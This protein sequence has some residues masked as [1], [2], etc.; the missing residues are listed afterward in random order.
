MFY[1]E[2]FQHVLKKFK[3]YLLKKFTK[4]IKKLNHLYLLLT[5]TLLL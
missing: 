3:F 4:L 2:T 1:K 5:N